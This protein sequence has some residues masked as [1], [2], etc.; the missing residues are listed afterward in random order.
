VERIV[1]G[2]TIALKRL[3][4]ARLANID[5]P[6]VLE[7]GGKAAREA[8]R[9]LI[10]AGTRVRYQMGRPA[11][12]S[13]GRKLV[14]LWGRADRLANQVLLERGLVQYAQPGTDYRVRMHRRALQRAESLA[15]RRGAGVWAAGCAP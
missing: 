15:Q 2:D 14:F 11:R 7:R 5:A 3:G 10:P 9:R 12:D 1:D 4:A 8:L 6:D 13:Y